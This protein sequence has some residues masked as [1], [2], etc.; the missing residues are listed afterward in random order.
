MTDHFHQKIR[1][2]LKLK[3]SPIQVWFTCAEFST[4]YYVQRKSLDREKKKKKN[5][6]RWHFEAVLP[7]S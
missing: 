7:T 3:V 4:N 1:E 5:F 6:Q 2:N